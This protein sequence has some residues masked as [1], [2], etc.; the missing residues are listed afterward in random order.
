MTAEWSTLIRQPILGALSLPTS[1]P[2]LPNPVE[3]RGEMIHHERPV[4]LASSRRPELDPS[5]VNINGE[6]I[7]MGPFVGLHQRQD[8]RLTCSRTVSPSR[9]L[10]PRDY[11]HRLGQGLTVT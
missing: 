5:I 4:D 8:H 11:M 6:A 7:A 2:S 3:L 10:E 1:T 9:R